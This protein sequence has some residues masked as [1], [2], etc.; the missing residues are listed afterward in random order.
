VNEDVLTLNKVVKKFK[1]LVA[2][3]S[4]SIPPSGDKCSA[5]PVSQALLWLFHLV[6]HTGK[7]PSEWRESI[8]VIIQSE[9]DNDRVHSH[10]CRFVEKCSSMSLSL[11]YSHC[12]IAQVNLICFTKSRSFDAIRALSCYQSSIA[13]SSN[14]FQLHVST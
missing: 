5:K 14:H 1:M 13:T 11:V 8:S 9:R 2:A 10:F 6:W 7:D 4:N 3:E 12:C